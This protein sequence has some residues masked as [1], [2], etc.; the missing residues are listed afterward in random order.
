MGGRFSGDQGFGGVN[1]LP[2]PGGIG[3]GGVVSGALAGGATAG[4][5]EGPGVGI[6]MLSGAGAGDG[7]GLGAGSEGTVVP[8][9]AVVGNGDV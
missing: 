2:P 5:F 4:S 7:A 8:R 6:P 3:A 9:S 1:G